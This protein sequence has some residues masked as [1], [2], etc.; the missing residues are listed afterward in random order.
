MPKTVDNYFLLDYALDRLY[1]EEINV[2]QLREQWHSYCIAKKESDIIDL[3][4]HIPFCYSKCT[5]CMHHSF[6]TTDPQQMTSHYLFF[7]EKYLRHF[8]KAFNTISFANVYIGGGTPNI[9][10]EKGLKEL[11]EILASSI[12]LAENTDGSLY[13]RTGEM[14]PA[15]ATKEQITI[16]RQMGINRIS[17]GIQSF[18]KRTLQ[19]VNR[20]YTDPDY[21]NRLVEHAKAIGVKEVNADLILGLADEDA[22]DMSRSCKIL[23][24][25]GV[26]TI[27][28]YTI[29]EHIDESKLFTTTQEFYHR[30]AKIRGRLME[31]SKAEGFILKESEDFSE[32]SPAICLYRD[33]DS[34]FQNKY[35]FH[36]EKNSVF[37]VGPGATGKIFGRLRY[38]N[39][40]RLFDRRNLISYGMQ[41]TTEDDIASLIISQLNNGELEES[42]II[43]R[44]GKGFDGIHT[45]IFKLLIEREILKTVTKKGERSL[46]WNAD[47][48]R[49]QAVYSLI[50][51]SEDL[52]KKYRKVTK[53]Y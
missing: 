47:S 40:E 23:R 24:S 37:A 15:W 31:E 53:G 46:V 5:Y 48:L 27:T 41:I 1:T 22:D 39:T 36:E 26:D 13:E 30:I 49:E 12:S 28:L 38:K 51:F 34:P 16:M 8:N 3:Y 6:P 7:L 25:S 18:C 17:F 50:F 29:Q 33:R 35:L 19:K 43:K 2:A 20:K 21:L 9:L 45:D 42:F 14:N 4:I 10:E 11:R 52:L 32:T 44:F